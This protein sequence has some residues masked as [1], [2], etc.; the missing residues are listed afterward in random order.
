MFTQFS[1]SANQLS[2]GSQYAVCTS[3][4]VLTNSDAFKK[5]FM[6]RWELE[7]PVPAHDEPLSGFIFTIH[8]NMFVSYICSA[9]MPYTKTYLHITP[10]S[11]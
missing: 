2:Y 4:S 7:R 1:S 9:V 3:G 11:K 5:I 8:S 10:Y 6:Q